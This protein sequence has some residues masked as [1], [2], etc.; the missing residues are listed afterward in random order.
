M[1]DRNKMRTVRFFA[2]AIELLALFVLQ[3]TPGLIPAVFSSRPVLVLPA[4]LSI[5]M[6]EGETVSMAFGIAGGLLID[7]G[8]GSVLGFHALLLAAGCY[9]ISLITANLF[10][11]NF[12]T[13][14]L[15]TAAAAAAVF[16]LQWVF[17]FALSGYAHVGYALSAHYFPMFCYTVAIMPLTY[18]FNRA[19]ALQVRS[20]EE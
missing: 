13:A 10:Q 9:L 5:A 6:F 12:L 15:L 18:Y 8:F 14:L 7:F 11:T 17:F 4:V 19:L 3:E 2:Y 1:S 20:K 16:L